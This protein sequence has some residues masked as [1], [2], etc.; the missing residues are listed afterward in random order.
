VLYDLEKQETR[1]E[2]ELGS[3]I[4]RDDMADLDIHKRER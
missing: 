4:T 1:T 2:F 3:L